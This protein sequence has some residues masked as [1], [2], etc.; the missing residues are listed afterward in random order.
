MATY[1]VRRLLL[2]IPTLLGITILV[3][4]LVAL[5]PGGVASGLGSAPPGTGAGEA[6]AKALAQ[7]QEP[8]DQ[9]YGLDSP[10]LVQYGR[11][12]ARVSPVR[13]GRREQVRPNGDIVRPPRQLDDPPLLVWWGG[14]LDPGAA[15]RVSSIPAADP[16]ERRRLFDEAY[17]EQYRAR[18]EYRERV[19]ELRLA[20]ERYANAAGIEGALDHHRRLRPAR[21]EATRPQIDLP[22]WK[23]VEASGR[24]AAAACDAAR[25]AQSKAEAIFAAKPYPDA[26]IPVI[27]GVL[28]L[29][30]PDFGSAVDGRRVTS[31]IADALP[32]TLLLNCV[33]FPII[34]LVAIPCGLLAAARRGSWLDTALGGLFVALW[35]VPTVWAGVLAV[36]YLASPQ[37]LGWFPASGL[38]DRAAESFSLLPS[39]REGEGLHRGYLLDSLWHLCLPVACLVYGGFAILSRQTRAAVLENLS[40]DYV[41]TARAK[42]VPSRAV[43]LRHVLRNSL[44][45]LITMFVGL[46]PALLGG[47]VVVEKIF[48]VPGMGMLMLK[49]IG[50]RDREVILA[51]TVMIAAISMAAL[52]LADILYA[53]A[54]P[55]VEFDA[56]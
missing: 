5:S 7:R 3:F 20:L 42:G 4:M 48:E 51:V 40:S 1:I 33:A 55:R 14:A 43:L 34:Y 8:L 11:W 50:E 18:V 30:W 49:A 41:R 16:A 26:G 13:F 15:Q 9:R 37:Y 35:S 54:D 27:P 47:S 38:H 32:I 23:A 6:T 53:L 29:A 25:R 31:M 19:M 17:A 10:V 44:L 22:E 21:L 24:T 46:F 28:W 36:G 56:T 45:P 52:L 2:A 12:L 39:W